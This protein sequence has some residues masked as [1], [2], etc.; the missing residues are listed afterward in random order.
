MIVSRDSA[1]QWLGSRSV[2]DMAARQERRLW[3]GAIGGER[4]FASACGL[5]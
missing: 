3:T 2:L 4:V 1:L 5:P